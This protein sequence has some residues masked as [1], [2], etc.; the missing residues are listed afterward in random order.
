MHIYITLFSNLRNE[1]LFTNSKNRKSKQDKKNKGKKGQ[2]KHNSFETDFQEHFII[3]Q[4]ES[5]QGSGQQK[6]LQKKNTKI[7]M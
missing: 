6:Q 7:M 3:G 5:K 4:Y 2:E 1:N